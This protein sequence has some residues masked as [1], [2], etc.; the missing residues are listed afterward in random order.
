[1]R[2]LVIVLV[3]L[4]SPATAR[5]KMVIMDP[6]MVRMCPHSPT[7]SG[8]VGCLSK[9]WQVTPLRELPG[10]HLVHIEQTR[11]EA[12][13]DLGV[14]LYIERGKEWRLAGVYQHRGA[15]YEVL[16]LSAQ[17]VGKH[18]GFRIDLGQLF[19]TTAMPDGVT[20][21]PAVMALRSSLY[22][23]GDNWRCT[24]ITTAC[25]VLVNGGALWSFHGQ[26]SIADNQIHI[27][28]DRRQVG[29]FCS[30]SETQFLGWSD[31]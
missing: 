6:P 12:A 9:T 20:R 21:I 28:G 4:S 3:A 8:V 27:A 2:W 23:G 22:C 19:R 26:V 17:T 10:A 7:W 11:G 15:D 24:E 1:M 30:V 29:P 5:A 18:A 13:I 16:G 25:D 14:L 31:Q